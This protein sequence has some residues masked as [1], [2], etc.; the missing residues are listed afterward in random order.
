M[1]QSVPPGAPSPFASANGTRPGTASGPSEDLKAKA[2]EEDSS[3]SSSLSFADLQAQH[4]LTKLP[5]CA[6]DDNSLRNAAPSA[7]LPATAPAPALPVGP[8]RRKRRRIEYAPLARPIDTYGGTDLALVEAI[9]HRLDKMRP[10]RT[11]ADLG[12]VD[13]HGLTMSLRSRLASEVSYALNA[14]ATIA[15]A[16]PHETRFKLRDNADLV[17]ELLDLLEETAFGLDGAGD[18]D[19]GE[20]HEPSSAGVEHGTASCPEPDTYRRLFS[21]VEEEAS[22]PAPLPPPPSSDLAASSSLR[23]A[24]VTLAVVNLVRTFAFDDDDAQF[25]IEDGRAAA[26]LVRAA[27]LPLERAR[28][29]A[30][31]SSSPSSLSV[32][33]VTAAQSMALKKAALETLAAFGTSVRLD[34]FSPATAAQT[35]ALLLFFVRHPHTHREPW[36]FDLSNTPGMAAKQAQVHAYPPASAASSVTGSAVPPYLDL[37]LSTFARLVLPDANRAVVA[38]LLDPDELHAL[39]DALVRLLPVAEADF[40]LM[41]FEVGIVHVHNTIMTLYNLAF[42][43][44]ASVRLRLRADPKAVK[45]LLRVVRRLVGTLS[46]SHDTE[47]WQGIAER[48]MAILRL[49]DDVDRPVSGAKAAQQGAHASL[50]W[51]GLSMSGLDDDD[52]GAVDEGPPSPGEDA[53]ATGEDG[54]VDQER[55]AST[56]AGVKRDLAHGPGSSSSAAA[57][58]PIL[59]GER[60]ALFEAVQMGSLQLAIPALAQMADAT[61]GSGG[62]RRRR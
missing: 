18:D 4:S 26:L 13:V 45:S 54:V 59:A 2:K 9:F 40:Q 49:L 5:S 22:E 24:E 37:G 47:I 19:V 3:A 35:V 33:H 23:P 58:G 46:A 48:C 50:P 36:A 41:T 30:D 11:I 21:L 20:V 62:R 16:P 56:T 17:E 29:C 44:P 10:R 57:A 53:A 55:R 39:F 15:M 60:R 27:S 52:A 34:A 14:L 12:T 6:A 25:L 43:A 8:P 42:L 7:P 38:R 51:W 31:S 32:V 1:A 28:H 61:R